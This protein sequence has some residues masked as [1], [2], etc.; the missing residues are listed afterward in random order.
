MSNIFQ[1]IKDRID[2]RDLVRFYGLDVNC[3][4]CARLADLP[5]ARFTTSE[6]PL[7]KSMKIISTASAVGN[8]ETIPILFR[9]CLDYLTLKPQKR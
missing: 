6:L 8:T 5:S 2:L 4:S 3:L 9:S 7:L 1:D